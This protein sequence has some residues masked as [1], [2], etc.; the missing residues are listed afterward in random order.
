MRLTLRQLQ[1]F[2]AIVQTGST[3]AAANAVSL[4]QSAA[5]AALSE[6]ENVL[7]T[8]V[9]DRVGKRLVLNDNGRTLSVQARWLLDG[10]AQVERQFSIVPGA[11]AAGPL[12]IG[13]STTIGNYLMPR[14]LADYRGHADISEVD[15]RIGNTGEIVQGV[16]RF[17]LDAGFIEGPSHDPHL[18]ALPWIRDE[19]VLI[20]GANHPLA[21]RR[22]RVSVAALR[23][24]V[25]LLREPG[26]GTR[27]VV[28]NVLRPHLHSMKSGISFG[29]SEAIKRATAHGLGI[30]CLSRWVVQDML[31]HGE[32]AELK[33]TLPALSRLFY[34][35]RHPHKFISRN[36]E[37]FLSFSRREGIEGW[38]PVARATKGLVRRKTGS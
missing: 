27:E 11:A 19:L 12:R 30:S 9:F 22:G 15:I 21:K 10:A 32:L 23:D 31:R 8:R 6:L 2:Q 5:S 36:L 37:Q 1:I 33:T 4:T 13:A 17:E 18:A 34:I 14:L 38:A 35:V 24:A 7:G 20:A 16:A 28:E 26:S 3:S 29:D 25:W